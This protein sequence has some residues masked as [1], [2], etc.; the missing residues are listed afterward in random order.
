MSA[1]FPQVSSMERYEPVTMSANSP[2]EFSSDHY[3]PLS[4]SVS[5]SQASLMSTSSHQSTESSRSLSPPVGPTRSPAQSRTQLVSLQ[6]EENAPSN[7]QLALLNNM[8]SRVK[9]TESSDTES[10]PVNARSSSLGTRPAPPPV[11]TRPPRLPP[12]AVAQKPPRNH[13]PLEV[14]VSGKQ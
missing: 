12:P 5:P 7:F 9:S 14:S 1:S 3:E 13:S 4:M 2:R 6:E 11:A 8:R 10:P